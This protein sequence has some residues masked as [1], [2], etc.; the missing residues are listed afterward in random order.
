MKYV[1]VVSAYNACTARKKSVSLTIVY[2]DAALSIENKCLRKLL[3]IFLKK[4]GAKCE[5]FSHNG[6]KKSFSRHQ[7]HSAMYNSLFKKAAI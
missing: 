6:E 3:I 4:R 1:S 2:I 7:L 5:T